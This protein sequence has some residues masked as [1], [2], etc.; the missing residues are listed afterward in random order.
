MGKARLETVNRASVYNVEV[1]P[2]PVSCR[3]HE[4]EF[5]CYPGI[6]ED[7]IRYHRI[8]TGQLCFLQT[9]R[10]LERFAYR[11]SLTMQTASNFLSITSYVDR[12]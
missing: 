1:S 9:Y 11:K 7:Y 12:M 6:I 2:E 10:A 8:R 5:N 4:Y 3:L